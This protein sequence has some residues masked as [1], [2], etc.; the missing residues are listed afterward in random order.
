MNRFTP[1]F[2]TLTVIL[3]S[4]PADWAASSPSTLFDK[5]GTGSGP[6]FADTVVAKGKGIEVKQSQ[7]DE[8]YLAFKGQ[9]AAMGQQVPDNARPRV[10]ADILDKLIAMQLFM[11]RATDKDKAKAKEIAESFLADQRKQAPSEESY[12][13]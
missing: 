12:R 9:R 2:I 3:L 5:P 1:I 4:S 11:A 7:V 10:E 6:L 13:R 8:M